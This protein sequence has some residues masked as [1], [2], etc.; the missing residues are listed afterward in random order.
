MTADLW[1]CDE[2]AQGEVNDDY[3]SLTLY[4]SGVALDNR[5]ATIKERLNNLGSIAPMWAED[6]ECFDTCDCCGARVDH[7][8]GF[9]RS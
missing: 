7:R 6:C 1:L 9:V 2:C 4:L 5:I 3:T 8:N